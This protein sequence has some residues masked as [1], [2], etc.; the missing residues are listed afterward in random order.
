ML[1]KTILFLSL[2]G[3]VFSATLTELL[4]TVQ[5]LITEYETQGKALTEPY[6]YNKLLNYYNFGKIYTAYMLDKQAEEMLSLASC[7][8]LPVDCKSHKYFVKNLDY[9]SY[10]YALRTM[11]VLLANVET[12]YNAYAEWWIGK[13]NSNNDVYDEYKNLESTLKEKFLNAWKAFLLT[14]PKPIQFQISKN[15]EFNDLFLLAMLKTAYYQ[16]WIKKI[17]YYGDWAN[18]RELTVKKWLPYTTQFKKYEKRY[19]K[20]FIFVY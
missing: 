20:D 19:T 9:Q 8:A 1:K 2:T 6:V 14:M 7:S 3:T 18:Y 13:R 10:L 17:V 4:D 11:P 15:P 16:G 12:A 5:R